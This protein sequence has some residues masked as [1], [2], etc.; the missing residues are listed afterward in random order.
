MSTAKPSRLRGA[1][2]ETA[3]GMHRAGLMN[4]LNFRKI[5][6][7]ELARNAATTSEHMAE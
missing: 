5:T 2:L 6:I 4:D 3:A 7:R 1:I